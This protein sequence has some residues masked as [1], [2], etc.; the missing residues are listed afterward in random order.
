VWLDGW[1][2]SDKIA[3]IASFVAFLQFGAL[4]ATVLIMVFNGR[5]QLRAY[6]FNT[7]SGIHYL[8]QPLSQVHVVI[9]N[10][11]QTPAYKLS[12]WMAIKL[13]K[14]PPTEPL[15]LLLPPADESVVKSESD[16]GP[17]DAFNKV[18]EI[19]L[20][21]ET[22][23]ALRAGTMAIY[24]YGE[25]RYRDAFKRRRYT[26]YRLMYGGDAGARPEGALVACKEGNK[27]N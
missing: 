26:K 24:V 3:A 14:F 23:A 11:G 8:D 25:I 4:I 21:D 7:Q 18:Q 12:D 6:V 9:K 16:F 1:S 15:T 2:L 17:G 22:K 5:R 20:S 19:R 10:S 13:T 27:A